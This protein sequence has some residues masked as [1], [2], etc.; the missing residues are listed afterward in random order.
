MFVFFLG[1]KNEVAMLKMSILNRE[2]GLLQSGTL[3]YTITIF[4]GEN[5]SFSDGA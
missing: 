2:V 4:I 5:P 1:V 3:P